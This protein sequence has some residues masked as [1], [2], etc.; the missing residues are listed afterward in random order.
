MNSAEIMDKISRDFPN[1]DISYGE[2]AD[3]EALRH[4]PRVLVWMDGATCCA[5]SIDYDEYQCGDSWTDVFGALA[6]EMTWVNELETYETVDGFLKAFE[7]AME[8]DV[9]LNLNVLPDSV[10]DWNV[11]VGKPP[12]GW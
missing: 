7:D 6:D 11:R 8:F 1:E 9:G 4:Q 2:L 10:V 5:F 3:Y 12:M